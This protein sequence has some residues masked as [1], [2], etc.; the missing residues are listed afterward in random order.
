[1]LT[2]T[3]RC[4]EISARAVSRESFPQQRS[5]IGWHRDAKLCS[6][7]GIHRKPEH[8]THPFLS[9]PHVIGYGRGRGNMYS[10]CLRTT[11]ILGKGLLSV[12]MLNKL[13]DFSRNLTLFISQ[14]R[15]GKSPRVWAKS[16]KTLGLETASRLLPL[17]EI[18]RLYSALQIE[19]QKNLKYKHIQGRTTFF[20]NFT[21]SGN[22]RNNITYR[23]CKL[24]FYGLDSSWHT[25]MTV[26]RVWKQWIEEG[27]TQRRAD[28]R[29]RDVTTAWDDRHRVS[30]SVTDRTASSTVLS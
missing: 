17:L 30:M 26:V 16:I 29:P 10:V 18:F 9:P 12:D 23:A 21:I 5:V 15:E 3:I 4:P 24:R 19:Q 25:A 20:S 28:T 2:I 7:C 22:L 14:F 27:R 1:M 11:Q 6:N 8:V 13:R